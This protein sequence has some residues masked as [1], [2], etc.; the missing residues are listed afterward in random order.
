MLIQNRISF[1]FS[2]LI[3]TGCTER[4][5]RDVRI[6]TRIPNVAIQ[7]KVFSESGQP[8]H[9]VTVTAQN[10]FTGLSST[11]TTDAGGSYLIR[12][13]RS[14]EY[15]VCVAKKDYGESCV[16][17]DGFLRSMIPGGNGSGILVDRDR[18]MNLTLKLRKP[19]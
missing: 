14:G 18:K 17:D 11:T 8:L 13:L 9:G 3:L 12:G 6:A 2:L 10:L 16:D 4:A 1:L 15:R 19:R 5:V 7:G